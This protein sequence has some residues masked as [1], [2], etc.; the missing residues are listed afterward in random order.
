MAGGRVVRN[1][2][3]NSLNCNH[4]KCLKPVEHHS[5]FTGD[6]SQN[7]LTINV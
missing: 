3:P 1:D 7:G 6:E 2:D 5:Q 4:V